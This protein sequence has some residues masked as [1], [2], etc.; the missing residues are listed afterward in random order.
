MASGWAVTVVSIFNEMQI[1]IIFCVRNH[2]EAAAALY[3]M[4]PVSR[5]TL[6]AFCIQRISRHGAK[7]TI[8]SLFGCNVKTGD[9]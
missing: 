4:Q 6:L 1:L 7:V 2:H 3:D 5:S 9:S 8:I